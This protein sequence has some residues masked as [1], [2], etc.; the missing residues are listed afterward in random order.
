[1]TNGVLV[2]SS[3]FSRFGAL[4]VRLKAGLLT[5]ACPPI[6][7]FGS[8]VA[9]FVAIF[10]DFRPFSTKFSTKDSVG[11]ALC[12][13]LTQM[14]SLD[15]IKFGVAGKGASPLWSNSHY[16]SDGVGTARPHIHQTAEA[17]G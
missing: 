8:F 16:G 4:P 1:M 11:Q 10:V 17:W 6:G 15:D 2:C 9:N 14:S 13:P 3:G 5:T 7:E 12:R